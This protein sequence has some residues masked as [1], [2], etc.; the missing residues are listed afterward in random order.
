MYTSAQG[1]LLGTLCLGLDYV[2]DLFSFLFS[3]VDDLESADLDCFVGFF[4]NFL[5][6]SS[7]MSLL[8]LAA[9]I[10]LEVLAF[11]AAANL[12]LNFDLLSLAT[13]LD[14]VSPSESEP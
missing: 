7:S 9:D 4:S 10:L 2:L 13:F 1:Y 12:E 8:A 11:T 14:T 3:L 6:I 5:I